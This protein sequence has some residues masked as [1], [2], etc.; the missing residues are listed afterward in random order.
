MAYLIIRQK[1]NNFK[2]AGN[3]KYEETDRKN[4]VQSSLNSHPTWETLYYTAFCLL[5]T[6]IDCV[7]LR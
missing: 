6:C 4:F 2:V 3:H 7:F 1:K 5:F